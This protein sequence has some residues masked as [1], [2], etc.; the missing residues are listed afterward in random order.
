MYIEN[1]HL[2]F[3]LS[4]TYVN[5][6]CSVFNLDVRRVHSMPVCSASNLSATVSKNRLIR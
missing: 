1:R 6:E 2:D 4:H 5:T 3:I